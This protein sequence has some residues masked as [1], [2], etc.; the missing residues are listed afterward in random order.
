ME[1]IK[2]SNKSDFKKVTE[3]FRAGEI[4]YRSD[5]QNLEISFRACD[6]IAWEILGGFTYFSK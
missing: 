5:E 6:E 4:S 3:L 2:F 1:T